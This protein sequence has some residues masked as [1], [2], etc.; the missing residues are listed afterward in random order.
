VPLQ[1]NGTNHF[2]L[3]AF[4]SYVLKIDVAGQAANSELADGL[5]VK[6]FEVV[7]SHD[8]TVAQIEGIPVEVERFRTTGATVAGWD[9]NLAVDDT[10]KTL[11]L[12]V[13]GSSSLHVDLHHKT[14]QAEP[15]PV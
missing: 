12:L 10:P 1:Y 7:V 3:E 2:P 14:G 8:G 13:T 15:L 6:S 4:S 5:L 11:Q 9:V